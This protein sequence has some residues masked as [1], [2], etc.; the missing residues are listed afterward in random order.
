MADFGRILMGLLTGGIS[1]GLL[2]AFNRRSGSGSNNSADD[3]I[4]AIEDAIKSQNKT[5][6][7][8]SYLSKM[9]N[10]GM[11]N[12]SE[13]N[14]LADLIAGWTGSRLTTAE[15]QAN[16]F[17]RQER[18]EAQNFNHNEAVDARMWQ[19][20]VEEN[21]YGWNTQS[22]QNAGINPALVYGGGNL[23]GTAA[24]GATGSS[25]PASSVSPSHGSAGDLF[26]ML[27]SLVRLP[28]EMK[29]LQAD[30]DASRA[31]AEKSTAE[32]K[33]ATMNAETNRM[34]AET[35]ARNATSR[36]REVSVQEMRQQ[37]DAALAESDIKVNDAQLTYIAKQ[38]NILDK[39]YSQMDAVLEVA[40]KNAD[41]NQQQAIA[42][43]RNAT[44]NVQRAATADYLANYQ[45]SLM[46][47]QE[48]MAW[49]NGEG[50]QIINKYLDPKQKQELEN[51]TKEGLILDE[52][53]RL[54][55][56]QGNL[57][58]AQTVKAYVNCATDISG[59]VN[60]WLNPF[61]KGATS[62]S[63]GAGF[64][65]SGAYQGVAYGYD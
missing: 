29:A 7:N 61:S 5:D 40:Q 6:G 19:Q 52:K 15:E 24:T 2:A 28:K 59:A 34:N 31:A 25:S 30:I 36:E 1:E 46:Y 20:Y 14:G 55:H 60:Q 54:I 12:S 21:K 41:S 63:S 57:V 44:A 23:V 65:L 9:E 22:M 42:A 37:V 26:N 11:L 43:L 56:K 8:P 32:G 16:A 33:A 35:N 13:G 47:A 10:T 49:A 51:L 39:Q 38:C 4:K 53:G 27:F 64:D 58:D 3:F 17:N 50:Q 48:L 62:S 45:S 18:I